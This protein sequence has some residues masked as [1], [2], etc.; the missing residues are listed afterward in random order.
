MQASTSNAQDEENP[1][2]GW[3]TNTHSSRKAGESLSSANDRILPSGIDPGSARAI[4]S[5]FSEQSS[6]GSVPT[7]VLPFPDTCSS[8]SYASSVDSAEEELHDNPIDHLNCLLDFMKTD[9]WP[10]IDYLNGNDCRKVFFS[11]LWHLFRPGTHVIDLEGKQA[12]RVLSVH[13]PDHRFVDPITK[14][15]QRLLGKTTEEENTALSPDAPFAFKKRGDPHADGRFSIY[16]VYL[17][18]DGKRLGPIPRLFHIKEFEDDRDVTSLCIYPLRLYD[19]HNNRNAND[20]MGRDDTTA[21]DSKKRDFWDQ[22][23]QRGRKFLSNAVVN[24]TSVQPRYYAGPELE[25]MDEIESQVVVDFEAAFTMQDPSLETRKRWRPN[26]QNLVKNIKHDPRFLLD[27]LSCSGQCCQ[28]EY[29]VD[30]WSLDMTRNNN[31][32][33]SLL[34]KTGEELPSVIVYPWSLNTSNPEAGLT[35]DDLVIMSYRVFGFVLR[36]RKWGMCSLL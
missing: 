19:A 25:S 14:L 2:L 17:D 10:R 6:P 27:E 36:S 28:K 35:E 24:L 21:S 15:S 31:F 34:P 32:M 11:D 7:I 18:V 8:S 1:V 12:Y 4:A 26:L 9:I 30:E 13:S 16:C 20:G 5:S 29:V 3:R 33:K 23:V 22:L